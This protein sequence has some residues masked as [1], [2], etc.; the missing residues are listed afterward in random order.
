L[1]ITFGKDIKITKKKI[2]Q[3]PGPGDYSAKLSKRIASK[4]T[5]RRPSAQ[6]RPTSRECSFAVPLSGE[7][8]S[9]FG[10]LKRASRMVRRKRVKLQASQFV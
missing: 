6:I 1:N 2:P 3:T 7:P 4:I 5:S 8:F 10:A 9:P